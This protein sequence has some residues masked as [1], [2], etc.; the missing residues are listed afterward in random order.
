M[1]HVMRSDCKPI[2]EIVR[3]NILK[4]KNSVGMREIHYR[5]REGKTLKPNVCLN[6]ISNHFDAFSL[7]RSQNSF[8]IPPQKK[9]VNTLAAP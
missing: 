8:G 5:H 3:I 9:T 4:R 6:F 1:Y 2:I 7:A